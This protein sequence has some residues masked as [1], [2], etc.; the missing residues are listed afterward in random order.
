MTQ[1]NESFRWF[2]KIKWFFF[3]DSVE[4]IQFIRNGSWWFVLFSS[5]T[6]FQ[7][8]P[9]RNRYIFNTCENT[10]GIICKIAFCSTNSYI[11]KAD[12]YVNLLF[13]K[14]F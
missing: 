9:Q 8:E 10:I 3:K 14:S 5:A 7:F 1:M 2:L 12:L 11:C 13:D 6:D 4:V